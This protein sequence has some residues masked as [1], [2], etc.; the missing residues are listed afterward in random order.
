MFCQNDTECAAEGKICCDS[1]CGGKMCV[2]S[3]EDM[4]KE[5]T[6]YD[7]TTIMILNFL[8]DRSGQTVQ[9]QIRL[10]L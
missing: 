10:L 2:L 5:Y 4:G 9:T 7:K 8:T 6:Q 1:A 3:L